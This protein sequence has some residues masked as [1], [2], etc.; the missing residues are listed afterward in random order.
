MI[1]VD[2]NDKFLTR[3]VNYSTVE[4]PRDRYSKQTNTFKIQKDKHFDNNNN[5]RRSSN[6]QIHAFI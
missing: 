1:K 3:T 2:Q 5:K 4:S 6:P